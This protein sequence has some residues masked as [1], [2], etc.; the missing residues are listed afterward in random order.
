M[1]G[2]S[3]QGGPCR[4]LFNYNHR[5]TKSGSWQDLDSNESGLVAVREARGQERHLLAAKNVQR[6]HGLWERI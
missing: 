2:R 6:L 4:I 3:I 5:T 1:C